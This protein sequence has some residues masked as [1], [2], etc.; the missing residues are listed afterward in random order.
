M[1]LFKTVRKG[2]TRL[3]IAC[4]VIFIL[5]S[6]WFQN[7]PNCFRGADKIGDIVNKLCLSYISSYI[8]Y[9]LVVH[10][11]SYQDKRIL[12]DHLYKVSTQII[13]ESKQM[14]DSLAN[15]A[16]HTIKDAF[17]EDDEIQA[18]CKRVNPSAPSPVINHTTLKQI[19]WLEFLFNSCQIL[20][21]Q[22]EKALAFTPFLDAKLLK[23]LM[24]I[25]SSNFFD[26]SNKIMVYSKAGI[27]NENIL[28]FQNPLI[29][30]FRL[31]KDL[32]DYSDKDL[33]KY[34]D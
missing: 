17:P 14:I 26:L 24:D 32:Q 5:N 27:K 9:F 28:L 10:Y 4:I 19:S 16:G 18:I 8:F 21:V 25:Q 3:F 2:V 15:A 29:E 6:V 12:N 1:G 13:R 22:I 34:L 11:K 7:I 31:I 33:K 20:K 23:C 30:Y